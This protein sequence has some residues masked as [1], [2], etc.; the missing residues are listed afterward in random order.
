VIRTV[1]A[2]I[3]RP[4]TTSTSGDNNLRYHF[5]LGAATQGTDLATLTFQMLNV[6]DDG[7]GTG[8]FNIDAFFN[9][10]PIG[11]FVH[12]AATGS[13]PFTTTPIAISAVNGTGGASDDNYIELRTNNGG[14]TA[15]WSNMD[16]IQ[17]DV[18]PVPEPSSSGLLLITL[19]GLGFIRRRK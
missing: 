13:T 12:T 6:D 3:G 16:Y 14:G 9:G 15:R 4:T 19:A 10:V 11:S 8:V 7:T 1:L 17:L 18:S 5:N 2:S